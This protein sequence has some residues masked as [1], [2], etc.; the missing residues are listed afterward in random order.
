MTCYDDYSR[1]SFVVLLQ[2]KSEAMQKL[3]GLI[4]QLELQHQKCVQCLCTDNGTEYVNEKFKAYLVERGIVHK[5]SAPYMHQ[6][7]SRAE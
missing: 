1:M 3:I 6:Q 7:N 5:T 2:S 4:T